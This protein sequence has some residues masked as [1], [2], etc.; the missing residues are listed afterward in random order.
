[1]R[2]CCGRKI[3]WWLSSSVARY[4]GVLLWDVLHIAQWI[5]TMKSASVTNRPC[6]A[7]PYLVY[8]ENF[9]K[10]NSGGLAQRKVEAKSVAY[11]ADKQNPER[12]FVRLF[13]EYK[14][15]T[16]TW[17]II[18]NVVKG[19][20]VARILIMIGKRTKYIEESKGEHMVL[21][22]HS[23]PQYTVKDNWNVFVKQ[24]ILLDSRQTTL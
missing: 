20:A 11:H 10:N 21:E 18:T 14:K 19:G 7:T 2:I 23:W 1:M 15:Q 17:H 4:H 6:R 12:C 16:I 8:T 9:S 22:C 5:G 24:R 13:K 3:A